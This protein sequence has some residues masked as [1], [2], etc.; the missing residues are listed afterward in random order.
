M[1]PSAQT[2]HPSPGLLAQSVSAPVACPFCHS[3][4]TRHYYSGPTGR[5]RRCAACSGLF[6]PDRTGEIV[7]ET[8]GLDDRASREYAATYRENEQSEKAIAT[9]VVALLRSQVPGA[10]R[11]LEIGCGNAA[12]GK[13][14]VANGE[15]WDYIG[16]EIS[17][18]L[19]RA[20]DP[21][22]RPRVLHGATLEATL[23]Q[24]PDGSQ[25]IVVL[26]HV[27]EHLPEPKQTLTLLRRKLTGAGHLFVEVPN[28]QWKKPLITLRRLLKRG[29]DEWFPGH[30]NFFT[31]QS[32]HA[33]VSASRFAIV[34]ERKLPA[35]RYLSM[36]KKMLGGET[37]FR[38]SLAARVVYAV[39]AV[40]RV[41]SLIGYGIVLRCLCRRDGR[42]L[43][44]E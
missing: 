32:L 23:Q 18:A 43:G 22:I 1:P 8:S 5:I 28:E 42:N 31:Q 20:I 7:Y 11:Y 14:V 41:E 17:P 3:G 27:L 15:G 13:A 10:R 9:E 6:N 19:Y 34:Y 26:H 16:I 29:G 40:T 4:D 12:I 36:V 37:A 30:I 44:D 39:L 35:G 38:N 24:V 25:D 21:A 33:L 2:M